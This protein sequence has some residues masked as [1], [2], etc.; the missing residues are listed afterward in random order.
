MSL[1]VATDVA[2][3]LSV[4]LARPLT[5]AI[6]FNSGLIHLLDS[7]V[8]TGAQCTWTVEFSGQSNAVATAE[9]ATYT[10]S[11]STSEIEKLA[12]LG[13]G[14]Y[15]KHSA[16]SGKAERIAAA[17]PTPPG[18]RS[19]VG[20]KNKLLMSRAER[21]Y[22]RVVRGVASDIYAGV[23][24]Q[25]P[26]QIV[27]LAQAVDSTG[28]Y[29][30]L[31]QGTYSEW[32]SVEDTVTTAALSISAV[33]EKLILPIFN[34]CG[35]YPTVLAAGST[36]FLGLLNLLGSSSDPYVR[37]IEVPGPGGTVRKLAAGTKAFMI[38]E[39]PVILDR[40]CTAGTIYG[41]NTEHLWFEQLPT[42]QYGFSDEEIMAALT[43]INPA[44][45]GL[46]DDQLIKIANAIR[47]PT[48]IL[49]Q[50][51]LLGAVGDQEQV[52]CTSY[53]QLVVELRN[54]HGKLAV[55]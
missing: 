2:G 5:S 42:I 17:V 55:T 13:F 48:G 15:E 36:I 18:A 23:T 10:P 32:A 22:Q 40:D 9:T 31:A 4:Y 30:G 43:M 41:L 21:S 45:A 34:A 3:A 35:K 19:L 25:N 52:I 37:G 50:F 46:T 6:N 33:R 51:K 7:K 49:P 26:E 54:A 24:G 20:A 47:N 11:D 38:D 39:I 29:A 12:S 27:G 14:K 53:A 44:A 16:V 1:T 8:A 28:T